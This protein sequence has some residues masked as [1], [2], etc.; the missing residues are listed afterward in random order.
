MHYFSVTCKK[1]PDTWERKPNVRGLRKDEGH[2]TCVYCLHVCQCVACVSRREDAEDKIV[3]E[4][5]ITCMYA[6]MSQ[7]CVLACMYVCVTREQVKDSLY[8]IHAYI[9]T[10][11]QHL[12]NKQHCICTCV[13]LSASFIPWV[14]RLPRVYQLVPRWVIP[15]IFTPSPPAHDPPVQ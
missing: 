13:S 5:G 8:L 9:H 1:I 14:V 2:S 11:M 15:L 10:C 4:V 3:A 6:C 12:Q 7:V